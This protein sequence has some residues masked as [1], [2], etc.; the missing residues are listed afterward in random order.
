MSGPYIFINSSPKA[1]TDVFLAFCPGAFSPLANS[2]AICS[3]LLPGQPA[4]SSRVLV[5]LND[6]VKQYLL[7]LIEVSIA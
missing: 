3:E 5:F 2:W 1:L 6:V 7:S 4:F